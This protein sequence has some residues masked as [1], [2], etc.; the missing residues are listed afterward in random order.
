VIEAMQGG[1]D[2][3]HPI[4]RRTPLP[5]AGAPTRAL[6]DDGDMDSQR[7]A[8]VTGAASGLG[9]AIASR[10]A[11]RCRLVLI[12][13][14]EAGLS[15]AA[16]E[17]RTTGA[18]VD[19]EPAD[20]T[21]RGAIERVI[22]S[23]AARGT[24]DYV[25]NNAGIG[26]TLPFR[27]ATTAHWDRIIDLN[28]RAVIDGTTAAYEV[29]TAQGRG[30]IV[31]TASIAGLVP[32]PLQTLYNTTKFAV[33]GLSLSLRPEAALAGVN[34]SVV[35]PGNVATAVFGKPILGRVDPYPRIP[36]NAIAP[37]EAARLVMTGVDANESTIVFP[38][39]AEELLS[40]FRADPKRWN[41]WAT[42]RVAG[43]H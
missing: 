1:V 30:H 36:D 22:Q 21:E 10:L 16:D 42:E 25:F 11:G 13:V 34:V 17:L 7:S 26:G 31:N 6:V 12:D 14:D 18:V 9:K 32:I 27:D 40:W 37:D 35:C 43:S 20:V 5:G 38:D 3:R 4:G 29:M 19:V 28:L 2:V 41:E 24:V 39:R 33:V 15:T 23:A 8:V